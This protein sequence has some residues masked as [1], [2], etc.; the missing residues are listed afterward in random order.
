MVKAF[1]AAFSSMVMI[2]A[3]PATAQSGAPGNGALPAALVLPKPTLDVLPNGLRVIVVERRGSARL[4][5]VDLRVRAGTADEP[6]GA[7]G[8]AHFLEHLLFK[9]TPTRQPGDADAAIENLGGELTAQTSLDWARFALT[10]PSQ[11]WRP[12]L[13]VLAD[14]IQNP[15]LRSDDIE[16]ERRVILDEA[17]TSGTDPIR[18]PLLALTQTAF[19]SGTR[20]TGRCTARPTRW[21]RSG[22]TICSAFGAHVISRTT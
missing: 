15:S 3:G 16:R 11:S 17:A 13:A 19:A 21:R 1:A 6:P 10:V 9:G 12:A 2:A 22:A 5:A 14:V 7:G 20:I 18:A 4:V 8:V